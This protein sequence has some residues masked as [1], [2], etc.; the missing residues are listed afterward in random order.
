MNRKKYLKVIKDLKC[1]KKQIPVSLE[2]IASAAVKLPNLVFTQPKKLILKFPNIKIT[3]STDNTKKISISIG[4][5]KCIYSKRFC[6]YDHNDIS[7]FMKN[8]LFTTYRHPAIHPERKYFCFGNY[9]NILAERYLRND[10]FLDFYFVMDSILRNPTN[11]GWQSMESVKYKNTCVECGEGCRLK[12][13]TDCR[14]Y[15]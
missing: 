4:T 12:I 1:H 10:N 11:E 9:G 8:L 7:L 14:I 15:A 2:S 6:K 13:C 3:G 5:L